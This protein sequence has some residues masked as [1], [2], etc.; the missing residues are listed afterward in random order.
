MITWRTFLV[1]FLLGGIA[2]TAIGIYLPNAG[3]SASFIVG[4][5]VT[6]ISIRVAESLW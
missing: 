3:C 6:F 1:A 2:G 4:A 5:L